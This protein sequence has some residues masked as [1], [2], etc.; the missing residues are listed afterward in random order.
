[1]EDGIGYAQLNLKQRSQTLHYFPD[2]FQCL[3]IFL[4]F[5]RLLHLFS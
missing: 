4:P 1:M 2:I 5:F 3:F